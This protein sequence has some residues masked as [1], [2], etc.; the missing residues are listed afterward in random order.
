MITQLHVD[1]NRAGE[2]FRDDVR[3]AT[4]SAGNIRKCLGADELQQLTTLAPLRSSAAVVLTLGSLAPV[5][6]VVGDT[7]G[8]IFAERARIGG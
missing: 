4:P 1:S 2:E 8:L 7:F 6:R 3:A 5:G